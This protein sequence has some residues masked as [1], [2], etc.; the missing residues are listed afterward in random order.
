MHIAC[1]DSLQGANPASYITLT[2]SHRIR[3]VS[4]VFRESGQ[5]VNSIQTHSLTRCAAPGVLIISVASSVRCR[6]CCFVS[7]STPRNVQCAAAFQ[8]KNRALSF[9]YV[10]T[11][12]SL[13]SNNEAVMSS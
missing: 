12:N 5:R 2:S 13:Y 6:I 1:M 8:T 7:V 11:L 9:K 10:A 4:N 3:V